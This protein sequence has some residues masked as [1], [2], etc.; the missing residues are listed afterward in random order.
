MLQAIR[1]GVGDPA[2]Q[3]LRPE[4]TAVDAILFAPADADDL[5]VGHADVQGAAVG[6]QDAAGLY[7]ALRL[8]LQFG[9]HARRP[10]AGVRRPPAP[11]VGDAVAGRK[12]GVVGQGAISA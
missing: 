9:I 8:P 6:T 5:A 2:V 12:F 4:P 11:D 7:P 10:V 3:P 1:A